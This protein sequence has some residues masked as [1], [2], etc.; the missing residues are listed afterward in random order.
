MLRV[1]VIAWGVNFEGPDYFLPQ[2]LEEQCWQSDLCATWIHMDAR[3]YCRYNE[4]KGNKGKGKGRK[5]NKGKDKNGKGKKGNGKGNQMGRGMSCESDEVLLDT[6]NN[7]SL[8][9]FFET[10]DGKLC[11]AFRSLVKL[12]MSQCSDPLPII[13]LSVACSMGRHRSQALAAAVECL[14]ITCT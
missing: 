8:E 10:C 7:A 12:V 1:P 13:F 6:L 3:P 5:D 9:E 4:G 11:A 14:A 2:E